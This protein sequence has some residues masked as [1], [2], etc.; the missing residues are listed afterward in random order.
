MGVSAKEVGFTEK[1]K[2]LFF[3]HVEKTDG[4]WNW[5]GS[6]NK[7]G[8]GHVRLPKVFDAKKS[9]VPAHRMSY[10]IHHGSVPSD[11]M[12][13]HKCDNPSCVNPDHLFLGTAKDN[14]LDMLRKGRDFVGALNQ[15]QVDEIREFFKSNPDESRIDVA[16]KYGVSKCAIYNIL[17]GRSWKLRREVV[18]EPLGEECPTKKRIA[19]STSVH[20]PLNPL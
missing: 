20:T 16:I 2:R 4:C 15:N 18:R 14:C 6:K 9:L 5:V 13:C 3:K 10:A 11:K 8:Y 1:T 19:E 12:V 7:R 17:K